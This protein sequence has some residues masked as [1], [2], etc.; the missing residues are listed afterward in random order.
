LQLQT[1]ASL[2]L[3]KAA[4]SRLTQKLLH[5]CSTKL[6]M[7]HTSLNLLPCQLHPLTQTGMVGNTYLVDVP[8]TVTGYLP[9]NAPMDEQ[10]AL[11]APQ[12]F[13]GMEGMV[14]FA[15]NC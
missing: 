11:D 3:P 5:F 10:S 13:Q 6:H 9:S 12:P 15:C 8:A 14:F 2:S 7:G 4:I 1:I